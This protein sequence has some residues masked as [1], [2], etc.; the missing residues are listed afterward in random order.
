MPFKPMFNFFETLLNYFQT[1]RI[2]KDEHKVK[3][4]ENINRDNEET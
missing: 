3:E 2:M 4:R 1:Q